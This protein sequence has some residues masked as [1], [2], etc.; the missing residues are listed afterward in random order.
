M[1]NIMPAFRRTSVLKHKPSQLK[2]MTTAGCPGIFAEPNRENSTGQLTV[3]RRSCLLS[4][5][6]SGWLQSVLID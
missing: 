6:G 2:S 4:V 3:N 5:P 1:R